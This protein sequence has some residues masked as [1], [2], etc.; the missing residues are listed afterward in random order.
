MSMPHVRYI[1]KSFIWSRIMLHRSLV[2]T[3]KVKFHP[4]TSTIRDE[5]HWL[6]VIWE[7]HFKHCM[8][9]DKIAQA[10]IAET[11]VTRC[12]DSECYRLQSAVCDDLVVTV[13]PTKKVTLGRWSF[14]YT[15]PSLW[16][17]L[18]HILNSCLTFNPFRNGLKHL[19]YNLYREIGC[20]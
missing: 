17:A 9:V 13:P 18:L 19:I 12:L 3:R 7:I 10:Y 11:C 16:N 2:V 1:F 8:L 6:L 14:K 15:V 4:I 5:L 20:L